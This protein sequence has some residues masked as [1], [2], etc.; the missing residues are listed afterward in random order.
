MLNKRVLYWTCSDGQAVMDMQW[1]TCSDG[2]A[3]MDK[4]WWTCYTVTWR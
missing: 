3:V 2:H 4:Q 1:W